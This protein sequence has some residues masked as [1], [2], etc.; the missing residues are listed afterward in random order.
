MYLKT[1]CLQQEVNV[2]HDYCG[3]LEKGAHIEGWVGEESFS[4][5]NEVTLSWGKSEGVISFLP[6]G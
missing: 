5:G 1:F 6:Q 2:K 4:K 3:S